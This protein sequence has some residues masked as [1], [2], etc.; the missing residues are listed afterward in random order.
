MKKLAAI[1]LAALILE[2]AASASSAPGTSARSAILIHAGTGE[3]LYESNADEKMLIASTTK[4]MTAVV[5]LENIDID[6][7]VTIEPGWCGIEGSSMYLKA[8]EEYSVRELLL[9][10]LLVSGNDAACSLACAAAG[11]IESFAAL[12]NEKAAKLGMANS[13]FKNPHGLDEDGHYSTARDMAR[14]MEYA[15]ANPD[16]AEITGCKSYSIGDVSYVNHNKLLWNCDGCIGGKTGYT[17]ASG[18]SLV[19]CCERGGARYICVTLGDPDDWRD[20]EA[21]YHWAEENYGLR[22]VIDDECV[23]SMPV[24]GGTGNAVKIVPEREV[25]LFLPKGTEIQYEIELP[26]FA[27]APCFEGEPA[28]KIIA[29]INGEAAATARLVYGHDIDIYPKAKLT[30]IERPLWVGRGF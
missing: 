5:V 26:R 19:S 21:L 10:M 28:G 23:L 22:A 16:F 9:G 20:H 29:Y 12:M 4:I 1:I 8:G 30:G 11:D 7:I 24:V 27:F 14:L 6:K 3:V 18:R 13:S 17:K 2:G 15:M 25:S